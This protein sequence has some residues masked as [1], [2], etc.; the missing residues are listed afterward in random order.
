MDESG[1][2]NISY[3][4]IA[5]PYRIFINCK[6]KKTTKKKPSYPTEKKPGGYCL[7]GM[8]AANYSFQRCHLQNLIP[9]ALL[10]T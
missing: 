10:L 7:N 6:N 1:K 5:S 2:R 4:P 9:L 8:I 3:G